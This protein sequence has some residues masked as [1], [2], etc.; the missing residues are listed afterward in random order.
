LTLFARNGVFLLKIKELE[1]FKD[2]EQYLR[3]PHEGDLA[4]AEAL[5]E[6][7]FRL[8][9]S[10]NVGDVNR[11]GVYVHEY[12]DLFSQGEIVKLRWREI[13]PYGWTM[14]TIEV[15]MDV[16]DVGSTVRLVY[17]V[18]EP[19]PES[20]SCHDFPDFPDAEFQ[21]FAKALESMRRAQIG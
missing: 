8:E 17:T 3:A 11:D 15:W 4:A 2:F 21:V 19:W 14:P 1:M 7:I 20:F 6:M 10:L 13:T 9:P 5:L 18:N 12:V 16:D